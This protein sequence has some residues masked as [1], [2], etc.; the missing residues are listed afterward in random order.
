MTWFS[1]LPIRVKLLGSFSL[2][3]ALMAIAT[4]F[5]LRSASSA[6]GA[7][8]D[9]YNVQFKGQMTL[10]EAKQAFL[11]SNIS[12]MDA[13]LAE[14]PGEAA[15]VVAEAEVHQTQARATLADYAATQADP[16]IRSVIEEALAATDV[17]LEIRKEVFAYIVAGRTAEGIDLNENGANGKP[18]GDKTAQ[19]VVDLLNEATVL[20]QGLAA[21]V[22]DDSASSASSAI[23]NSAILGVVAALVGLGLA[24]V[25][26]QAIRNAVAGVVDRLQSIEQNCITDLSQGMSAF[27]A[28][29]LTFEVQP[30]TPR[31]P[32]PSQDEVGRA[33][34]T[35]NVVLDKLA[36]TIATYN[37]ARLSLSRIVSDVRTGAGSLLD[38]SDSLKES[39]DQMAAATSQIAEAITDVTRSA[40]NLSGLSQE[41]AREVEQVAAGSVQLAS[42][43][44]ANADSAGESSLEANRM[45][46]SIQ[47][48]S[49]SSE[50]VAASAEQSRSAAQSGQEA[51]ARA[52][53][54]MEAIA[55][56]V[57]RA[58]ETVGQLGE[59]G[60]QIGDIVKTIDEIAAQTNLL[61]LNAAIEA[62]RAGEQGRGFAVVAENVR[63]L[64]ERSS[65]STKEIADLIAKVQSATREAVDVMAVGVRDVE[66]GTEVTAE[67][68]R[69]LDSII[70]SVRES[71]VQMQQIAKDVQELSGA[72]TRIVNSAGQI[73]RSAGESAEAASS[74]ATGTSRVTEAILQVSAT[75]EE[76]SASA[77]EV[78]ASTEQLSA[79][80]QELAATASQVKFVAEGLDQ[81]VARFKI[82]A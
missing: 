25:I 65:G 49:S 40:V 82:A 81:A 73:S 22:Q 8:S 45:Q 17:L 16:E 43:A 47:Y 44:R 30:T 19:A 32:R 55:A 28:G 59:F 15:E 18:S 21:Q 54:S 72:A 61:A 50:M 3:I 26:S 20:S 39:S 7:T 77:E 69:A 12:T 79:Q 23:R 37:E 38:S 75:S 10:D 64:A 24:F 6:A 11:M 74:M 48:V 67:A 76:T 4:I 62:A 35:I 9:L 42:A 51:V 53:T 66:A 33:G 1:N 36:A 60:Q 70:A 27:A 34:A 2:A 58:A 5:A 68:G 14:D 13:L 78:S 71:A 41:S 80:S 52:M 31:I 57:V 56:A 29:D 46:E 63:S